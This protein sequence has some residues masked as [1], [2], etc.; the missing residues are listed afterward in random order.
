MVE[1]LEPGHKGKNALENMHEAF[2]EALRHREQEIVRYLA[3]LGPA[4]G[5][6]IWLMTYDGENKETVFVYG[7]IGVTVLLLVGALYALAL[8]YNYRYITLELAKLESDRCLDIKDHMLKQ[9]PRSPE[10]FAKRNRL[11][12][13]PYCLPPEII[14]I[15]LGAFVAG[16]VGVT[17]GAFQ[18]MRDQQASGADG[19][20]AWSLVVIG[21]LCLVAA[22]CAPAVFGCKIQKA[23]RKEFGEW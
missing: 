12:G 22:I 20:L 15:F 4:L 16:I 8:G 11:W 21:C 23:C 17:Y 6:F 1:P 3:I 5:G 10:E 14:K 9:W 7:T 2:L 18:F 13:I 19:T